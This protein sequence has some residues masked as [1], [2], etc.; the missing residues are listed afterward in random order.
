[1]KSSELNSSRGSFA[2]RMDWKSVLALK[3]PLQENLSW[4]PEEQPTFLKDACKRTCSC[5]EVSASGEV[6]FLGYNLQKT[7]IVPSDLLHTG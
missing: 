6:I 3:S 1:V 7:L 4:A 2:L 5:V